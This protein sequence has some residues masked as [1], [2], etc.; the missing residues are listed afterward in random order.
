MSNLDMNYIWELVQQAQE[1]DSNA[2]AEFFAATCQKQFIFARRFLGNDYAAQ[3][4]LQQTYTQALVD[5][6]MIKDASLTVAWLTEI[7]LKYCFDKSE[8]HTSNAI[9]IDG[10]SVPIELILSLPFTESQALLLRY[11]CNMKN[12]EISSFMEISKSDVRRYLDRATRRI[13][14]IGKEGSVIE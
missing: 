6:R 4:V 12:K 8:T 3:E 13:A 1:G 2:F 9:S 5:L 11:A 10:T 7:N 14:N